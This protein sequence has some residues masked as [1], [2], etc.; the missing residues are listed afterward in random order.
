MFRRSP[1]GGRVKLQQVEQKPA[2]DGAGQPRPNLLGLLSQ[3]VIQQN[4]VAVQRLIQ[5]GIKRRLLAV[6][7]RGFRPHAGEQDLERRGHGRVGVGE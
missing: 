7:A 5:I 4:P 2:L 1:D 6:A 3:E